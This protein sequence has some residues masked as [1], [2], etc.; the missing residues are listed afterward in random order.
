[1]ETSVHKIAE[2]SISNF[3]LTNF[4][5]LEMIIIFF[6]TIHLLLV[7][8]MGQHL[9]TVCIPERERERERERVRE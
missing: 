4:Y 9:L 3:C 2:D 8:V 6:I 7:G 5:A 1:M